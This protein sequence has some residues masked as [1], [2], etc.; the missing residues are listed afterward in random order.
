MAFWTRGLD[1][2]RASAR[3]YYDL[4][5]DV[6]IVHLTA[7]S[8][9]QHVERIWNDIDGWWHSTE[10]QNARTIFCDRYARVSDTPL[11]DIRAALSTYKSGVVDMQDQG[12]YQGK[13]QK[14]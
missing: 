11:C 14:Q 2:V 4:L 5:V 3:P 13:S 7:E 6:G 1:H 8:C 10:V 12:S 9:S